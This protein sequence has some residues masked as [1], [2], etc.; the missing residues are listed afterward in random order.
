VSGMNRPQRLIVIAGTGTE[1]GKTWVG[2]QLLQLA[3]QRGLRVAARKPAQSFEAGAP[4]DAE[5]LAEAT[6]EQPSTICPPHRWYAIPMAPPMAADVLGRERLSVSALVDEI[7]WAEPLDLGCVEI[8]GGLRSP[9]AHDGDNADL[10]AAL[11]PDAI[12]LV[13]D[14]GL[15]T[16]NSVR[17]SLA[18][19]GKCRTH[20]FLNRFDA[21]NDLHERNRIW[22][23]DAY[24]IECVV[25]IEQL[26]DALG[27]KAEG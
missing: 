1:V 13:A 3:R 10:I 14:A 19:L 17:M 27:L 26:L 4:T 16:I 22:L 23:R 5:A 2:S 12:V 15:G 9:I 11:A 6:G 20:V 18:C 8:A 21:G 25:G 24:G 7:V